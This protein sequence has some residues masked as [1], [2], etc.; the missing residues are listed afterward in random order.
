[1][2]VRAWESGAASSAIA[3]RHEAPNQVQRNSSANLEPTSPWSVFICSQ[4]RQGFAPS[5]VPTERFRLA[6]T[7][8]IESSNGSRIQKAVLDDTQEN[9]QNIVG[10]GDTL[11]DVVVENIRHDRI[12]IRSATATRELVM[13]F[14]SIP[15]ATIGGS[16]SNSL[17]ELS[18]AASNRLGC[19]KVQDGRWQFSRQPMLDYYQQLLDEPDRMVALFD[20]MKPVRDS[21]NKITGYVV[22]VEGEKEFFDVV[23]LREGDI[24]RQ[25]NSVAM[26]NRRRAEFFIDE[27]LKNR[28]SAIV[29]DVE[30]DG[31]VQKQIYQ[32]KE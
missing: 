26:T 11:G 14:V 3:M 20:T 23:G 7:F 28:M 1:V 27:F 29:L 24:V 25:V 9:L 4:V 15:S 17:G 22:G 13:E 21:Q 2:Y 12:T 6:G 19:I 30:R 16:T 18:A 32:V 5:V 8:A 31:K 10:E